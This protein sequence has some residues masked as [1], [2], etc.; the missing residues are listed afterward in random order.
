MVAG[1]RARL[2]L[3]AR[4]PRNKSEKRTHPKGVPLIRGNGPHCADG[5]LPSGEKDNTEQSKRHWP[6][7]LSEKSKSACVRLTW[8][9]NFA[10]ISPESP[11]GNL[12]P[13]RHSLVPP[14][15]GGREI[16]L[17]QAL[18]L[19]RL[20]PDAAVPHPRD[21]AK[22]GIGRQKKSG[23]LNPDWSRQKALRPAIWRDFSYLLHGTPGPAV[24]RSSGVAVMPSNG[25]KHL[26]TAHPTCNGSDIHLRAQRHFH[27]GRRAGENGGASC[28]NEG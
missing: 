17:R 27:C 5:R 15:G 2:S 10:Q 9:T 14:T 21:A 3:G 16:Y 26:Q 8:S 20:V 19:T 12:I 1:G 6:E 13:E 24:R 18:R 7:S 22:S 11:T 25:L 4:L 23:A 28:G